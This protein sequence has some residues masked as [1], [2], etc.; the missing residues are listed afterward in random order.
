[1]IYKIYVV[2]RGQHFTAMMRLFTILSAATAAFASQRSLPSGSLNMGYVSMCDK[3]KIIQ[4][5]QTG[6]NVI[7]W[8]SIDLAN[9]NGKPAVVPSAVQPLPDVSCIGDIAEK[10]K[11]MNLTTTHLVSVGGWGAPHPVTDFSASDMW[12]AWKDWN[13]NVIAPAGLTGGFDGIDWDMEGANDP[14]ASTNYLKVDMMNLVGE[15][16][17][18]AKQDG[19]IVSLVPP[20]SYLDQTT[21]LFDDS[22]L[23]PYP[24]WKPYV[25]F[26][27]HG[28]NGYAFLL[29]KYGQTMLSS[30]S[31]EDTFDLVSI[32]VYESYTHMLYNT[33]KAHQTNA[34]YLTKWIPRMLD[35]WYIDFASDPSFGIPSQTISIKKNALCIGIAN[36][37]ADNVRNV[38]IMPDEASQAYSALKATGQE[39]RG[40]VFWA[41][42]LEGEV[43]KGQKEPL[44]LAAGLNEFLHT[45]D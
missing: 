26:N 27:Y 32:Q 6:V 14:A 10:L 39:P 15:M 22:L 37:W 28:H 7:Y 40:F 34:D 18:L 13:D 17:Q 8:F 35:G 38:L 42:E 20:E 21:S 2:E 36:G 16:S 12:N 29:A 33:T 30:G 43:P 9:V 25:T 23:H 4:A 41:V 45:R 11:M 44:Y 1:L 5:V 19:F 24:E 31:K 3:E